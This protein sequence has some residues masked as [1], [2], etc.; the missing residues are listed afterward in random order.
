MKFDRKQSETESLEVKEIG[1][2]DRKNE[3]KKEGKKEKERKRKRKRE[4]K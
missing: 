4:I 2:L 1:M 3:R